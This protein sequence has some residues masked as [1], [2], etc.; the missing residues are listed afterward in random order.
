[1]AG[2]QPIT[3][4]VRGTP[5][6]YHVSLVKHFDR[7]HITHRAPGTMTDISFNFIT[8]AGS[9]TS[10]PT[11]TISGGLSLWGTFV[12]GVDVWAVAAGERKVSIA[13]N[14]ESRWI[15]FE[16]THS[17]AGEQFGFL[18]WSVD[19]YPVTEEVESA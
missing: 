12:W 8:P 14:A 2:T 16:I 3:H 7:V 4:I 9:A 11:Y 13:L 6:A 5:L 17:Q 19:A 18:G 10:R 15:Q 1:M